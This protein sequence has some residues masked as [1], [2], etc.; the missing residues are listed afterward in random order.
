MVLLPA[1]EYG[2]E[3]SA[4]GLFNS[5]IGNAKLGYNISNQVMKV[6][7]HDKELFVFPLVMVIVAAVELIMTLA[8]LI[9]GSAGYILSFGFIS[10]VI[11]MLVYYLIVTFTATYF[12]IALYIAFQSFV[13]GKKMG[14]AQALSKARPY[15]SLILQWTLFYTAICTVIKLIEGSMRGVIGFII[16]EIAS[17]G[18]WV[19]TIFA[20]PVIYE[21]KVGPIEAVKKSGLFIINNLGKTFTGIIYFNLIS[22]AIKAIGGL[23]I[24][25]AIF[26]GIITLSRFTVRL[27]GFVILRPTSL[28]TVG[29]VFFVGLAIFLIGALFNYITLHLYYLILYDY[30]KNNKIPEGMDES[31]I[32]SSFKYSG[33]PAS[34]QSGDNKPFGGLF[35]SG[36]DD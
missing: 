1:A 12:L 8:V 6:L 9:V 16:Q 19:A 18:L 36:A 5:L 3:A 10:I 30:V 33:A 20:I 28:L 13:G 32:K 23:S 7:F 34:S 25:S 29:I 11:L 26:M 31:L 14:L 17:I 24:L 22:F 21:E 35:Q 27:G 2:S 15:S 4:V